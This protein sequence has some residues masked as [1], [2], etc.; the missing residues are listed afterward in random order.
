MAPPTCTRYE[1]VNLRGRYWAELQDRYF[2]A[3]HRFLDKSWVDKERPWHV[4]SQSEPISSKVLLYWAF[5][6]L[7]VLHPYAPYNFEKRS[8]FLEFATQ[9]IDDKSK[10]FA[11]ADTF[12]IWYED[13]TFFKFCISCILAD[14]F[15]KTREFRNV[16]LLDGN[17]KCPPVD[18][19][20][21]WHRQIV[22]DNDWD[23]TGG[24]ALKAT[25]T[26][27]RET[28]RCKAKG[29]LFH[30]IHP[31]FCLFRRY[32]DPRFLKRIFVTK[33]CQ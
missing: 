29:T 3:R 19:M 4:V 23:T 20:L 21:K 26:P 15:F 24:N 18:I 32:E 2:L 11:V 10:G 25:N 17:G 27:F 22:R 30:F 9:L 33:H 7:F 8:S 13:L 28:K 6:C 14:M 5:G 31:I 16:C 1:Q 12:N